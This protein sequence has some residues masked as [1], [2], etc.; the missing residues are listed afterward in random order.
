ML[1]EKDTLFPHS[2][3]VYYF[4]PNKILILIEFLRKI[5]YILYI[6]Y[7]YILLV[8]FINVKILELENLLKKLAWIRD[9]KEVKNI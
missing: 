4:Y 5:K 1:E 9:N 8:K 7:C 2:I 6:L 3:S